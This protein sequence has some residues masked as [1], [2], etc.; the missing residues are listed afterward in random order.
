MT[1]LLTA[2]TA[3]LGAFLIV[4]LA[5]A[6]D[7]R[8]G[9]FLYVDDFETTA[10]LTGRVLDTNAFVD[11]ETELP[12]EGVAV[13]LLGVPGSSI[14][15]PDG[16]F[17]LRNVPPG[18]QV[19][20][21]DTGGATPAPTGDTYAGFRERIVLNGFNNVERPFYLPRIDASSLICACAFTDRE[22]A[23]L[24]ARRRSHPGGEPA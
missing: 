23:W 19:L 21:L 18:E 9:E 4:V 1:N 8:A 24:R 5:M 15:G 2:R 3:L 16:S 10:T 7:L 13:T 20:D 22:S 17:L 11:D 12:V 14:T 6:P